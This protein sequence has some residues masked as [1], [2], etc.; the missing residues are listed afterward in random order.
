MK[1]ASFFYQRSIED[2]NYKGDIFFKEYYKFQGIDEVINSE[3]TVR[4][5]E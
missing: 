1:Q 4:K 3:L 2:A 5:P